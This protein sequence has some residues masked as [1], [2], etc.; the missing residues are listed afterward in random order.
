MKKIILSMAMLAIM[1][2]TATAQTTTSTLTPDRPL[3]SGDLFQGM[4]RTIPTGRV[5]LLYGLDVTFDK[6]VHL[7]FPSAIRYVDLG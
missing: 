4:S 6:T 2:A 3:S 5:V 1:G 7:I